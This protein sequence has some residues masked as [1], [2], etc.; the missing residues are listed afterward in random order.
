MCTTRLGEMRAEMTQTTLDLLRS[1]LDRCRSEREAIS[2]ADLCSR[3]GIKDRRLR[4]AIRAL[5]LGGAQIVTAPGGGYYTAAAPEAAEEWAKRERRRAVAIF[6]GIAGAF[7]RRR[8]LE[9]WGQVRLDV[10]EAV[11]DALSASG[12]G[13]ATTPQEDVAYPCTA[14]VAPEAGRA[15]S[16]R[17]LVCGKKLHGR[18]ERFC[19]DGHRDVYHGRRGLF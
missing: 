7:G 11:R 3:C 19:C 2:R 8:M 4:E 16:E 13:P 9:M 5:R 17:C 15:V 1:T 12:S 14:S 6:V 10:D 18:Q